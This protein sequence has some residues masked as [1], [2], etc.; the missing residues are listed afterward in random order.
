MASRRRSKLGSS[1]KKKKTRKNKQSRKEKEKD[2][3]F[4][5]LPSD[6]LQLV[7]S[8][9]PLKDNIRASA[10]CKT[11]HEACVSLRVVH[12]SPWLIYFSKTDDS[13]ELYDP[14]MQKTYNLH[15]PELSGFR[16]CYS[17]DGWLLMYN[18]NS[19]Q[20]LFF[21]PFTRDH[22]PVPPLWM[23]YDQRMAFSCAPTST[24]CLLFTVSSVTWNYITIKKCCANAKEWKTFV[25]KNRLQRN[26]NTFE[27]I[28]FSNGV[29]YCLTNTGCLPLF[30]PSLNS[31][32]VLPGRP[33][34]RPGSNGCFMTEHQGEIFLIYMYRHMNPTVLKLD[35]TSFEWAERKTLGGL[36]IYASALCSESRAE[37]QKQSGIRN[38][39]CLSVFHGFKRTCIYYK[40][41]E[42]SEICFKWKKQNPYENIWIMPPLNLI[43]LPVFDQRI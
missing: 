24:S 39:L 20:L 40:V 21:N 4:I 9:L 30:D 41:D 33:P 35:L 12:T 6:L 31:W 43:D 15:F 7:I 3:T 29:F 23:A 14:S 11:W 2:Q 19:Y 5:D 18:A 10:V 27:Q 1:T 25:F 28:V 37:Q 32:N 22:I 8:R 26:F 36:T 17:K 42:E 38:C 16:V 34:K 13:Y